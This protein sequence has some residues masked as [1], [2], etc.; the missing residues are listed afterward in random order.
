M[1][2]SKKIQA[3]SIIF[4]FLTI[5]VIR[6]Q[7]LRKINDDELNV[8]VIGDAGFPESESQIK[9]MVVSRIREKH[10]QRPFQLGIIL[11]DN[12]YE[13]GSEKDDFETLNQIFGISFPPHIFD[14]D[15][16]TVLGNHDHMGDPDTQIRFH[17]EYDPRFYMPDRNYHYDVKLIDN[18]SIRFVCVDSTPLYDYRLITPENRSTIIRLLIELLDNSREFDYVFLILHHNVLRGCGPHRR[19]PDDVHFTK[20]TTHKY[21]SA[22]INGHNHNMQML[23]RIMIHPPVFTVGNSALADPVGASESENA[24]CRSPETGGFGQLIISNKLTKIR[25]FSGKG[26]LLVD[27]ELDKGQ[28]T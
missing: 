16:L 5:F 18:T 14:F 27:A 28:R 21:L 10:A 2:T 7:K 22:I 19:V 11:G 8:V 9:R 15:F 12:V 13:T 24:W 6:G 25:Y 17:L 26:Q 3:K 4:C 20:L 1:S 23:G